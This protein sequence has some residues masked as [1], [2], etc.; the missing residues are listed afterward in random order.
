MKRLV[1]IICKMHRNV[2]KL[3]ELKK[4]AQ[5]LEDKSRNKKWF[6][7]NC[8]RRLVR[9]YKGIN[10]NFKDGFNTRNKGD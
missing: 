7:K 9:T 5:A 8:G 2:V 6:C 10:F 3:V 1:E 4:Y